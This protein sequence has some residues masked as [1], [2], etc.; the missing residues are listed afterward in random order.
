MN[1]IHMPAGMALTLAVLQASAVAGQAPDSLRGRVIGAAAEALADVEV[2]LHRV[3]DSGGASIAWDTTGAAGEFALPAPAAD[4]PDALYFVAARWEGDL[5]IA[6]PFASA[7][8]AD[9]VIVLQVGVPGTAAMSAAADAGTTA[10]PMGGAPAQVRP[11][12][13][14]R[15]W[16]IALVVGLALM[17]FLIYLA[18]RR[19]GGGVPERN[20]LLLRVALL[21]EE[22]DAAR[23][24]DEEVADLQR[25]H[26]E[27]VA[28]L[29]AASAG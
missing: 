1:H 23:A 22:L 14:W 5:Y 10:L 20:Q 8:E 28:R 3:T 29:R 13:S 11:L 6:E 18:L 25:E 21:E 16:G 7:A 2:V 17:G 24:A 26:A 15:R 9:S 27:A 12:V 19:Q 4:G